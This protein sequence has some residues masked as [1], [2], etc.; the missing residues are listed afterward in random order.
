MCAPSSLFIS[1]SF[2]EGCPLC[3]YAIYDTKFSL[4]YE[5]TLLCYHY[6]TRP[7]WPSWTTW[8][9]RANVQRLL[10]CLRVLRSSHSTSLLSEDVGQLQQG[11]SNSTT[12]VWLPS[13]LVLTILLYYMVLF[14]V[15]RGSTLDMYLS[16]S[17][18]GTYSPVLSSTWINYFPHLLHSQ[19]R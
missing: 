2:Q 3:C 12:K 5:W 15:G 4:C 7:L 18:L 1:S 19:S 8:A 16:Y 9:S 6:D 14:S 11:T 13:H 17:D 10:C